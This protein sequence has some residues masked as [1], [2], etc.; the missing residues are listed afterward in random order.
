MAISL[1][2]NIFKKIGFEEI[3]DGENLFNRSLVKTYKRERNGDNTV[4]VMG[5]IKYNESE[6]SYHGNMVIDLKKKKII[7]STCTCI[8]H[9]DNRNEKKTYMCK[10]LVALF[11][12]YIEVYGEAS[13]EFKDIEKNISTHNNGSTSEL[14]GEF[15]FDKDKFDMWCKVKFIYEDKEINPWDIKDNKMIL[16]D[17]N[18]ESKIDMELNKLNFINE[19]GKFI[20]EGTNIDL[21][22]FL[23]RDVEKLKAYGEVY[24]SDRFK[25]MKIHKSSSIKANIENSSDDYLKFSFEIGDIDKEEYNNILKAFKENRRFYKLSDSSFLDLEDGKTKK[26]MTLIQKLAQSGGIENGEFKIDKNKAVML[27]STIEND[28][29]DFIKGK[30]IVEDIS[31][32]LTNLEEVDY[33]LPK[34]LKATL[35]DYQITGYKW[36]KTLSCLGFGGILADEMGLGKTI[37]TIAFLL[38]EIDKKSIIVAPTSLIY[39]WNKE[40]EKFAPTMKIAVIH[41]DRNERV[42]LMNGIDKYDVVITTY[43]TLRNDFDYYKNIEFDYCIIDEGQNIKNPLSQNT[44]TIKNIKAK[45]RFALSGTPIENNLMELWSLFDFVMP[46]YLYSKSVFKKMFAGGG[47][48]EIEDL[49]TL[50]NPFILRRIKNEVM[51]ELPDKIEKE[52]FVEMTEEQKKIYSIFVNEIKEKLENPEVEDDA[53][54]ILSYLTKLRQICLDPSIVVEN[55]LGGSGKI[56]VVLDIIKEATSNGRKILL[57][58]QF[59]TVLKIIEKLLY[60]RNINCSYLDGSTK[61]TERMKLVEEF[62]ESENKQIFLISLKAGGTGLNLTSADMVIHFDPWWNPAVEDQA[63][64]RAHRYGQKNVVEVIK[65]IAEGSIE[66]QILSLQNNKKE[67]IGNVM[68]KDMQN[69]GLISSLSKEQIRGLLISRECS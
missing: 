55:Y 15:Y 54:T 45:N 57:F 69:S 10:H 1:N 6:L 28:E 13:V 12:K 27:E 63:T 3:I 46:G 17:L 37:Q 30:K 21:Y 31:N 47:N 43:G 23:S 19:D 9:Y 4:N 18:K 33:E 40:F 49:K 61:A 65:L 26:F 50:I 5:S 66:E 64:D 68:S 44:E 62:N 11:L 53:I 29:L 59:T 48:F 36:F 24:Y 52:F 60:E 35:R 16:R 58:S 41:G 39:N 38:S 32:R 67:L 2:E 8:E 42:S 25:E 56:N 34:N 22:D 7:K 20:F 51:K 14:K